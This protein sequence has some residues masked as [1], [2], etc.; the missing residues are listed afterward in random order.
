MKKMPGKLVFVVFFL[1]SSAFFAQDLNEKWQN[2][3]NNFSAEE[4]RSVIDSLPGFISELKDS[5]NKSNLLVAYYYMAVS[6]FRTNSFVSADSFF[7]KAKYLAEE[8]GL[9]RNY[10]EVASS[11]VALYNKKIKESQ[12]GDRSFLNYLLSRFTGIIDVLK[13]QE[14]R[15]VAYYQAGEY[16]RQAD[17]PG[18]A[19]SCYQNSRD[20]LAASG[21]KNDALEKSLNN[22]LTELALTSGS[23]SLQDFAD[24]SSSYFQ[25]AL[26]VALDE[27]AAGN[28]R[29]SLKLFDNLQQSVY[30]ENDFA[31]AVDIMKKR[32]DLTARLGE[33]DRMTDSVF[34]FLET[35]RTKAEKLDLKFLELQKLYILA[36]LNSGNLR[37]AIDE[38]T[39]MEQSI[40]DSVVVENYLPYFLY[41]RG[42]FSYLVADYDLA[43]E[44][45][46]RA[47]K[48]RG[49][50]REAEEMA[51]LNNLGLA[52][53]RSGNYGESNAVFEQLL[54][55]AMERRDFFY[56]IQAKI[57]SGIVDFKQEQFD[58]AID[59]FRSAA[60]LAKNNSLYEL[61]LICSIRS[62]EVY[63]I[64]GFTKAAD[65]VF[66]EI[67]RNYNKINNPY[68][69]IS[70]LSS[71]A[72]NERMN[73]RIGDALAY[74]RD[75][76]ELADS[77]NIKNSLYSLALSIA[78]L[79]FLSDSAS[80]ALEYYT[81]ASEKI[82]N[83]SDLSDKMMLMIKQAKCRFILGEYDNAKNIL[84]ATFKEF[85]PENEK[86]ITAPKEKNISNIFLY[87]QCLT[88]YS[89]ILFAEGQLNN[90]FGKIFQ[91]Y[92]HVKYAIDLLTQNY[93]TSLLQKDKTN[94][95]SKNLESFQLFIDIAMYLSAQTKDIKYVR[96]AFN[97]SE[98]SRAQQFVEELGTQ[99]ASRLKDS[100]MKPVS[101]M[102]KKFLQ[103]PEDKINTF[104]L[105]S[106][107]ENYSNLTRGLKV[108]KDTLKNYNRI[109]DAYDKVLDEL[110]ENKSKTT[111]LISVNTLSLSSIQSFLKENEVIINYFVNPS[112]TYAFLI[113]KN[114][115]QGK[116]IE[117]E[118]GEV[119]NLVEKFR[120]ELLSQESESYQT[121]ARQLYALFIGPLESFIDGKK[122]LIIPSGKLH[123]L[124]FG[125]LMRGAKFMTEIY[126]FSIMPNASSI[127]FLVDKNSDIREQT[128]SILAVGNPSND[129]T[130]PLPGAENE[131][132]ELKTYFPDIKILIGEEASEALIKSHLPKYNIVHFACHGLFNMDY[133][134]FSALALSPDQYDD[135][136]LEVHEL[137]N[138]YLPKTRLVVLSACETGLAQIK[139]NDDMVGLVRGFLF[140]G[141][142]EVI[143]SLWKVDDEA[144]S[145]LMNNFYLYFSQG[146]PFSESLRKAQTDLINSPSFRHPF[147][148]AAFV[149]NGKGN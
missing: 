131:V 147:Y 117:I 112:Q 26:K 13:N 128:T 5:E 133:P 30:G 119:E 61:E 140:A 93:F 74:L 8:L 65:A 64:Q 78:D 77:N 118:K 44:Y 54:S 71:I 75:A 91:S 27:E 42:D 134:L 97:F 127:Q 89:Y 29:Q 47:L 3:Q 83:S 126:N 1:I 69:K 68:Q 24:T 81:L 49:V 62:G 14:L 23:E 34:A 50:F 149:L 59:K 76:Y 130:N 138:I 102:T 92:E 88:E 111:E 46:N 101:D 85:L 10:D 53:Y 109:Q 106:S 63:Q 79:Y 129:F 137:Y 36:N 48:S 122:V 144:T 110:N 41:L 87:T 52:Y 125:A 70:A 37:S 145:M 113:S 132:K 25:V 66:A 4:F 121:I 72:N 98:K 51:I 104:E 108:T 123:N 28:L 139:K 40:Y 39:R 7:T 22:I 31:L 9:I 56:A 15:A 58:K 60:G 35:E 96:E 32:Y 100:S 116:T 115:F 103:Q 16:Y 19:I 67:K 135:G 73:Q 11:Q 20:A 38:I 142:P 114:D 90:D 95:I 80:K 57:N 6:L 82:L 141:V 148:W 105:A 55:E 12:N 136:K 21:T 120:Q 86:N 84:L 33:S 99:L 18:L 143:A 2:I 124:P 107:D 45:Y 17:N 146:F 94:E 43:I